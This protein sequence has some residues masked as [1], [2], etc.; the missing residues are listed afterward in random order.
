MNNKGTL[1]IARTGLMLALLVVAQF[2]GSKL[3]PAGAV[4]LGPMSITQLITG[5]LVNMILILTAAVVGVWSGIAVGVLSSVLALVLG[6][7]GQVI[8]TPAIALGNVII[9]L[10]TWFF[11]SLAARRGQ[12]AYGVFGI[13]GI[14]A[15]AA[16]KYTFLWLTVPALLLLL[17]KL[18][19]A[20]RHKM[21]VMFSFPQLITALIGGA[22]ALTVIPPIKKVLLRRV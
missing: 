8:L 19:S 5:S 15:G 10:V 6:I 14:A 18:P 22:L 9:V 11:F 3:I 7:Q 16:L 1:W 20:V 2:V 12:K 21:T 17:A 4:I 13:V